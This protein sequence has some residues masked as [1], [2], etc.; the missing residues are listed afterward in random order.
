[1]KEKQPAMTGR[2]W[3]HLSVFWPSIVAGLIGPPDDDDATAVAADGAFVGGHAEVPAGTADAPETEYDDGWVAVDGDDLAV[4]DEPLGALPGPE[5]AT[6]DRYKTVFRDMPVHDAVLELFCK[7]AA[8][9]GRLFG[10][11][12]GDTVTLTEADVRT[13]VAEARTLGVHYL[14]TLYGRTNTSKVH[15]VIFHLGDELRDCGNL[16]EGDTSLN[17]RLH[18][19]CKRMYART[20]KRGPGVSLQMMRCEQTQAQV[21]GEIAQAEEAGGDSAVAAGAATSADPPAQTNDLASS[22]RGERAAVGELLARPELRAFAETLASGGVA[23]VTV[24]K[25]MRIV[26]RFEWGAAGEMQYVRATKSFWGKPWHSYVRYHVAG[27]EVRWGC[28][29]LILRSLGRQ[30][31]HCVVVQRLRRVA[32][33]P[34]CVLSRYG[35]VR[36]AWDFSSL[37]DDYP[38]LELVDADQILRLED[39]QVDWQDLADRHGMRAMPS[40]V[41]STAT[42][43]RASRFFTNVFYPWTSRALFPAL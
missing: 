36:L 21:L 22:M 1:M 20:N 31:R 43:R 40:T 29:A 16:W 12:V 42:E 26:A 30:Q 28:S 7:A 32:A 2:S 35:C 3:R 37:G 34:A 14:Q 18:G 17:E 5:L 38:A 4:A 27:G 39:V 6:T 11:N 25:T 13:M 10:D 41:E 8:L 19:A 23:W 9:G 15:R 33:R 24:A